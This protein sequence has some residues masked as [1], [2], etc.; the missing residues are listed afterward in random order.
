MNLNDFCQ[1]PRKHS[2]AQKAKMGLTESSEAETRDTKTQTL[3]HYRTELPSQQKH[4][5]AKQHYGAE[6]RNADKDSDLEENGACGHD[7]EPDHE[8][9]MAKADLYKLSNYAAKLHDMLTHISEYEGLQGWQQAKITKAADYISAVYH[10]LDYDQKFEEAKATKTRLDPSCWA[11]KKIGNPKTKVKGGVRVNNCVP[12]GLDEADMRDPAWVGLSGEDYEAMT[13]G[14]RRA[15]GEPDDSPRDPNDY[16]DL[17]KE[18]QYEIEA[19][20]RRK[21]YEEKFKTEKDWQEGDAPNGKEYNLRYVVT[22]DD[23]E[24]IKNELYKFQNSHDYYMRK[25]VDTEIRPGQGIGYYMDVNSWNHPVKPRTSAQESAQ[26]AERSTIKNIK[27]AVTGT[28]ITSRVNDELTQAGAASER[29]DEKEAK[30]RFRRYDR[31]QAVG[32]KSQAMA[33]DKK[34]K[35]AVI[36]TSEPVGY[37][38][39][40]IGPGGKEHNVKTNAAWDRKNK[41]EDA[42]QID[43]L[44]GFGKKKSAIPPRKTLGNITTK[45][46]PK[47]TS[48][49]S[50]KPELVNVSN[51]TDEKEWTRRWRELNK[52]MLSAGQDRDLITAI[53]RGKGVLLRKAD[54]LNIKV[55]G[56]TESK[57]KPGKKT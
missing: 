38:I 16:S 1:P 7:R 46:T 45:P 37:R 42:E 21:K 55:P 24:I 4:E 36:Q 39:A 31:L 17:S 40:D 19:E 13:S 18:V 22:S 6:L 14:R 35:K 11:G 23:P 29:G 52:L 2:R 51:I 15:R 26:V 53:Q 49:V 47:F 56:V 5:L 8:V 20:K 54:E 25:L 57:N 34:K 12:E 9:N 30:K 27:R 32:Q 44:F 10:S 43:E 41:K 28:D 33:E 3:R 48:A 50:V